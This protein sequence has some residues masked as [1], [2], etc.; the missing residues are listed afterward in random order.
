MSTP[1]SKIARGTWYSLRRASVRR[2]TPRGAGCQDQNRELWVAS[3]GVPSLEDKWG[4]RSQLYSTIIYWMSAAKSR[5]L[6]SQP[7]C[8][9]R[10]SKLATQSSL[11]SS[12]LYGCGPESTVVVLADCLLQPI[13]D[14]IPPL[15][16]L[17][18]DVIVAVCLVR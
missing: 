14:P 13:K 8:V 9:T 4:A 17:A 12:P 16:D 11:F 2:L 18:L 15:L 1:C 7:S 10:H 6:A 3:F 5:E